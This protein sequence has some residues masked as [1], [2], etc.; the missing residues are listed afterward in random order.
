MKIGIYMDTG[1]P[2]TPLGGTEYSAA[3]L[4]E[5]LCRRHEVHLVHHRKGADKGEF[6]ALFGTDLSPVHFRYVDKQPIS[7]GRSR[8][9]WRR[10]RQARAWHAEVSKP[11]DFFIAFIHLIP[12]YCHAPR[13]MFTILFPFVDRENTWPWSAGADGG[14][15]PLRQWLRTRYYD[16]EWKTRLDSYAIKTSN[17]YFTAKWVSKR[18]G[19][20]CL[21][22][23][24]P[25]QSLVPTESKKDVIL[26]VGRFSV[27]K[28][29]LELISAF[30]DISDLMAEGWTYHTVGAVD[31]SQGEGKLYFDAVR[32]LQANGRSHVVG[33]MEL[34]KLKTLYQEAKIF[35]HAA[36]YAYEEDTLPHVME[37]FGIVTVEAM[38]AG[39]VPIVIN[40]GGQPEIVEHGVNGF[41]WRTLEELKGYTCLLA[42]DEKLRRQ[43]AA[44][45]VERARLFSREMYV[46]RFYE[47]VPQLAPYHA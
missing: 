23:Y 8:L 37:H 39:C 19:A 35:W 13:G 18:Y 45:A 41:L 29:Q 5:E 12:P 7:F 25:S 21:V 30:R 4:A 26:S 47:L 38:S 42:K 10:I 40:K 20:P 44:A 11:Y 1:G 17:S 36:G 27:Y 16:W 34:G 43:M 32:S 14:A 31:E 33:N 2:G 3:V 9:P 46:K 6:L 15:N 28:N 22:H 24:P